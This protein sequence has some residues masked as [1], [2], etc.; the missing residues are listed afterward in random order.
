MIKMM[1]LA[2]RL[3]LIIPYLHS[4]LTKNIMRIG[5]CK[6]H[7]PGISGHLQSLLIFAFLMAKYFVRKKVKTFRINLQMRLKDVSVVSDLSDHCSFKRV[8]ISLF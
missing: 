1:S 8:F 6:E 4:E 5:L 7:L 3:T 2:R